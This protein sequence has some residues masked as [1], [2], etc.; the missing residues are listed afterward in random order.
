MRGGW[1]PSKE[2]CALYNLSIDEFLAWERDF[3]RNGIPGLR[4]TRYQTGF[5][6]WRRPSQMKRL[7]IN[8][9]AIRSRY[10]SLTLRVAKC[11]N[12]GSPGARI[13]G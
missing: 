3:D 13:L 8:R 1:V 9:R 6:S 10:F 11:T 7:D 12:E 2:A 5:C 4:S